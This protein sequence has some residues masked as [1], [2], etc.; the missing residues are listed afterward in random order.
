MKKEVKHI[1]IG[2]ILVVA[3]AVVIFMVVKIAINKKETPLQ[4]NKTDN[5]VTQIRKL[6]EFATASFYEEFILKDSKPN[7][8]V[9]NL[10]GRVVSCHGKPLIE[11]NIVIVTKGKVRAGF[12]L[13]EIGKQDVIIS[14]DT[15]YVILPKAQILDVITN[16]SDFDIFV[17]DGKWSQ[18]QVTSVENKAQ[19]QL[20]QDAIQNGILE[21][22]QK[23]GAEKIS[24]ILQG[25]E[26]KAV[27]V[28]M[29]K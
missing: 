8:L 17:E 29:K 16:P 20:K 28:T 9:D 3:L 12:D 4:I 19:A 18:E 5:V 25:L 22:A 2:I 7:K 21:K 10:V 1:V 15:L 23:S 27:V 26:Y 13:S 6:S 11:D 14:N 24:Q